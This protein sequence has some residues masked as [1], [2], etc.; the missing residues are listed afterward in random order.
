MQTQAD[1]IPVTAREFERWFS[2]DVVASRWP[3]PLCDLGLRALLTLKSMDQPAFAKSEVLQRE[4]AKDL[5]AFATAYSEFRTTCSP[6]PELHGRPVSS[7]EA[8]VFCIGQHMM[9]LDAMNNLGR[10]PLD[11][12]SQFT[13]HCERRGAREI[14]LTGTNTD[15]LLFQHIK[16]LTTYLRYWMPDVKLGLRTNG[17]LALARSDAFGSFDKVSLSVHSLDPAIYV[18]MMGSGH[19]PD[20][21]QIVEQWGGRIDFKVNVVLGPENIVGRDVL[22]TIHKLE[23]LGIT[24]VN[25]RE[26]YGQPRVGDVLSEWGFKPQSEVYGMPVYR[27]FDICEVVYWDVHFV[28]VESVNLYAN[29]HVSETYPITKG[30][31]PATGDV[32]GQEHFITSGRVREQWVSR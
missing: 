8:P 17:A 18:R 10:W 31:D 3:A 27:P 4:S 26:P 25:V 29:G 20:I 14:N 7:A 13:E 21:R 11:G 2:D 22:T 15:P 30:H 32:R 1:E 12:L 24:K 28:E 16:E 6:T 9:A 19:P 5:Q 23:A